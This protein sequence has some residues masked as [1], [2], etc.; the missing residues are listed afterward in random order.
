MWE[1]SRC[2]KQSGGPYHWHHFS[3]PGAT[4]DVWNEVVDAVSTAVSARVRDPIAAAKFANGL[5]GD[6]QGVLNQAAKGR[7]RGAQKLFPIHQHPLVWELR[8]DFKKTGVFRL[9]HA[10]PTSHPQLLVSLW[11]HRKYTGGTYAEIQAAQDVEIGSAVER[12][13]EGVK[14]AWGHTARC[15]HCPKS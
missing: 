6:I 15:S 3:A 1:D 8:W 4:D 5:L 14:S 11:F 7:L 10:E 13:G 9:Y 2:A 12:Y